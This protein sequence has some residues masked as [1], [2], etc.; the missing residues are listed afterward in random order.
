MAVTSV[1]DP[2]PG[3]GRARLHLVA[4]HAHASFVL[5]GARLVLLA[6]VVPDLDRGDVHEDDD[7]ENTVVV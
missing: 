3:V 7:Q 4:G 1:Q 2:Q 6:Q 5:E